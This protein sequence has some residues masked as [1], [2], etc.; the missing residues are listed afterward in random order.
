M[1]NHA[2]LLWWQTKEDLSPMLAHWY[3]ILQQYNFGVKHCPGILHFLPDQLSHLAMQF[4]AHHVVITTAHCSGPIPASVR[5]FLR[6]PSVP[7]PKR[8][9]ATNAGWDLL[10]A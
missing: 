10:A 7:L 3:T 9:H 4:T 1:H 2:A 6:D 8:M 5:V